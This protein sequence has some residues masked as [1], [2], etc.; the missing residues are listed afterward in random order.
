MTYQ[1][2]YPGIDL[3]YHGAGR[4]LEYDFVVAP[5][6]D[7]LVI[8]LAFDGA[9]SVT[10]SESGELVIETSRG[11]LRQHQPRVYQASN[12]NRREIVALFRIT[13]PNRVGFAIS[14]YDRS[15]TLI[16]E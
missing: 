3:V 7:P 2:I 5:G 16:I 10:I 11:E 12:G 6:A 14:D 4:Q 13:G 8:E 15:R 1:S 9:R